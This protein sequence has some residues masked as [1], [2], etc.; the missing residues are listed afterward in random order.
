MLC[1]R[2]HGRCD[3][4]HRKGTGDPVCLPGLL[5]GRVPGMPVPNL[6][7]SKSSFHWPVCCPSRRPGVQPGVILGGAALSEGQQPGLYQLEAE[8]TPV[9]GEENLHCQ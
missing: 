8:G 4:F 1:V 7:L 3:T 2:F 6:R 5:Q 9:P